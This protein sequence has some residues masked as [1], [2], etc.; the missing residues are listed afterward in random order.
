MSMWKHPWIERIEKIMIDRAELAEGG[1]V[2][3]KLSS[4]EKTVFY[5]GRDIE[6]LPKKLKEVD[7]IFYL[8]F[9]NEIF[10]EIHPY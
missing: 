7:P 2:T 6:R 9:R 3:V 4:G 1:I 10:D 5:C 8:R